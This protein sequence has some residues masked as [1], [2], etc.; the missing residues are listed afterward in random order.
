MVCFD[1]IWFVL[2]VLLTHF[3]GKS[4]EGLGSK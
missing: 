2:F 1:L 4:R 3:V